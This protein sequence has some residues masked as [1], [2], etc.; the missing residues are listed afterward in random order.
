MPFISLFDK[1][2]LSSSSFDKIFD[3]HVFFFLTLVFSIFC[4]DKIGQLDDVLQGH[5]DLIP[6][7]GG[8]LL[9]LFPFMPLVSSS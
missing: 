4:L 1:M 9:L 2:N 8:S 6:G 5:L 7:E 3:N